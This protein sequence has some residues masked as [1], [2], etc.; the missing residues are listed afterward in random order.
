LISFYL[1]IPFPEILDDETWF[2]K[3]RQLEWLSAS[4]VLGTKKNGRV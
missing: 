4:G 2:E 1:G 3:Y